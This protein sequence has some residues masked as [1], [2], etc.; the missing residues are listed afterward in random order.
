MFKKRFIF[1][2]IAMPI[3]LHKCYKPN[4]NKILKFKTKPIGNIFLLHFPQF[5]I[6]C[7]CR[8]FKSADLSE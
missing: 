1:I 5:S 3:P 4:L 6:K 2:H 7:T 8:F